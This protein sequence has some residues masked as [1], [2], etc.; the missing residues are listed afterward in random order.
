MNIV[1]DTNVIISAFI[2]NGF[3]RKVFDYCAYEQNISVYISEWIKEEFI[4]VLKRKFKMPDIKIE[5][6]NVF[7]N[8]MFDTIKPIG[9]KPD[10][11]RDIDDNNILHLAK[12]VNA[13]Y[14]ITGDKDL[15]V[16][17]VYKTIKIITPRDFWDMVSEQPMD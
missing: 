10:V 5:K 16:L 3:S 15:L 11:C 6:A 12:F 8:E 1:I 7:I 4:S 13:D 17:E 14:I 2:G 9:D